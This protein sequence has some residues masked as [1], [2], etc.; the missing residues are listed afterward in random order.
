MFPVFTELFA[1]VMRYKDRR[2]FALESLTGI[3][4][5]EALISWNIPSENHAHRSPRRF[6]INFNEVT[7]L[8]GRNVAFCRPHDIDD[9]TLLG[10]AT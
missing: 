3:R 8:Y 1:V 2:I 6:Q 9:S 10:I 7:V 5:L 4:R